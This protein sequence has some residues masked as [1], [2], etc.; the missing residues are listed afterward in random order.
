MSKNLKRNIQKRSEELKSNMEVPNRNMTRLEHARHNVFTSLTNS[1]KQNCHE[2]VILNKRE[3]FEKLDRQMLNKIKDF[4]T[5]GFGC[6]L[7]LLF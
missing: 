2:F 5:Q 3:I 1:V 6:F 7:M 4:E